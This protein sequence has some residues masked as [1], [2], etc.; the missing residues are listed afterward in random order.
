MSAE[1]LSLEVQP[2]TLAHTDDVVTSHAAA[3]QNRAGKASNRRA[4]LETHNRVREHEPIGLTDD[5]VAER[6]GLELIEA[7]RR[8]SDLRRLGLIEWLMAPILVG[9]SPLSAPLT[10]K[11]ALGRKSAVSVITQAGLEALS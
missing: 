2:R 10:R 3:A 5:E 9:P 6:T 11:T 8:C 1:Q 4:C 7:R